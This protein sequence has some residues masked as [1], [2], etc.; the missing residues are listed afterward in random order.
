MVIP[1]R[2][3]KC[4]EMHKHK[5]KEERFFLI[6]LVLA[7]TGVAIV[8]AAFWYL[9]VRGI[10]SIARAILTVV[11]VILSWV[12]V[13]LG[14]GFGSVALTLFLDRPL[15]GLV[16]PTR[17]AVEYLFPFALFFGQ[18]LGFPKDALQKA[19]IQVSNRLVGTK[20]IKILGNELLILLPHCIQKSDCQYKVT[21]DVENCRRCG[22]CT[23]DELLRL[24][25]KYGFHMAVATGGTLAR[26]VVREIR[27]KAIVAVACERD[28]ASGIMDTYPMPVTGVLNIRP[29]GPCV[30]TA[31]DVDEV[32]KAILQ[33]IGGN[34]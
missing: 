14:V 24:K 3:V 15:P 25:E 13:L 1:L 23:L 27:P 10:T 31:V 28:L 18:L 34:K 19:F 22:R 30:N 6:L 33:F 16:Q 20:K 4:S 26:K 7:L 12:F 2:K 32:E 9:Q 5:S 8:V 11:A 29:E 17:L 21:T